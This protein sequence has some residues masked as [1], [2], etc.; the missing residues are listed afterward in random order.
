MT[1][2]EELEARVEALEKQVRQQHWAGALANIRAIGVGQLARI[3]QSRG[4]SVS[5]PE[6]S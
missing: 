6:E 2:V 3:C 1:K 4:S 5:A